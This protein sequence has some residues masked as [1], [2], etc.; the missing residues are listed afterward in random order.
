MVSLSLGD[1]LAQS[2]STVPEKTALVHG[3]RRVSYRHLH[4]MAEDLAAG[5]DE[6]GFVKG[7]RVAIY[8]KNSL[9]FVVAFYALQKMGVIVAW[10][11]PLYRKSES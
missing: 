6:L 7:D 9:E 1:M 4:E 3:N 2:A 8:M 10:V 5:M 11:N